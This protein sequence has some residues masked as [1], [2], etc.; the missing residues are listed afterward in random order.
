VK[1][2]SHK[3]LE[4]TLDDLDCQYCLHYQGK[5]EP[6]PLEVCCCEDEKREVIERIFGNVSLP[7]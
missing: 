3:N 2:V 4:Y 6:C 7:S 5:D 1:N